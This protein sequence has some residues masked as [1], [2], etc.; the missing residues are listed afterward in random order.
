M[1]S[2]K[3]YQYLFTGISGLG[4][5]SNFQCF[6]YIKRTFSNKGTVFNILA[7][8]S[9][10]TAICNGLY[11]VT[12]AISLIDEDFFKSKLG[13]VIHFSGQ[14]LPIVLGP[15]SSLMISACRFIQL[16]F[17]SVALKSS[18][19][20]NKGAKVVIILVAVYYLTF[21]SVDTFMDGKT[22]NFIEQCQ[23][24]EYPK[25]RNKVGKSFFS[26]ILLEYAKIV[27][28]FD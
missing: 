15:V 25:D 9:L 5:I 20:I 3:T 8:D 21:M 13:C 24:H 23:G 22:Y 11:F 14:Y 12:N 18:K 27:N 7:D 26:F 19:A 17:P 16:R 6:K 2:D 4:A 10:A 28:N 1:W